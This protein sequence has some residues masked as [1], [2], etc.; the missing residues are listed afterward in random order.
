MISLKC[1]SFLSSCLHDGLCLCAAVMIF[2]FIIVFSQSYVS[3]CLIVC[4][5]GKQTRPPGLL[6]L[7]RPTGDFGCESQ[8]ILIKLQPPAT[9]TLINQGGVIRAHPDGE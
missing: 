2:S 8:L 9:I 5:R 1:V 7:L 6:H 4:P 3:G